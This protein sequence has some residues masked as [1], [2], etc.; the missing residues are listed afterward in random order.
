MKNRRNYYRLLRV[1][2]D[3]SLEI[4]KHSYRT[5]MQKLQHHPD[6]GG[7]EWNAS[8]INIAYATLRD[9]KK[10][11]AYDRK[12][13]S[14]HDIETLSRGNLGK[15]P[16]AFK[17]KQKQSANQ[18]NYY[19]LLQVQ[20]DAELAVIETSYKLLKRKPDANKELLNE[21]WKTLQSEVKRRQYD[22]QLKGAKITHNSNGAEYPKNQRPKQNPE[23]HEKSSTSGYSKAKAQQ[24]KYTASPNTKTKQANDQSTFSTSID[25]TDTNKHKQHQD[26]GHAYSAQN[27]QYC[28]FCHTPYSHNDYAHR[29]E[30]CDEC[31]SPLLLLSAGFSKLP[32]RHVARAKAQKPAVIYSSWPGKPSRI[33]LSDLSPTG[34][35]FINKQPLIVGNLIKIDAEEFKAIAELRYCKAIGAFSK[36]GVHFITIQFSQQRGA[37][38]STSV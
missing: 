31:C 17:T 28:L 10:R 12:L 18:R 34:L 29:H 5:L 3:A 30:Y 11:T 33:T 35:S 14:Q 37:F 6:L 25:Q 24:K 2:P 13:F 4:I 15:T 16:K 27:D 20:P 26:R 19:R 8:N 7:E 23:Q 38:L 22:Q 1:Q 32:R 9:T 36:I 21:A